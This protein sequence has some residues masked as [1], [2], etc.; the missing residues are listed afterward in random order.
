MGTVL[1]L[2]LL[3]SHRRYGM[4]L[5][6]GGRIVIDYGGLLI[7]FGGVALLSDERET[8]VKVSL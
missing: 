7:S 5:G 4:D 2:S 3:F 8:N 1:V 6:W